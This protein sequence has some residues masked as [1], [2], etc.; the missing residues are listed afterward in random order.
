MRRALLIALVLLAAC[1]TTTTTT[2]TTPQQTTTT[3]PAATTNTSTPPPVGLQITDYAYLLRFAHETNVRPGATL[4]VL[5][6]CR[7]KPALNSGVVSFGA[8]G[9]PVASGSPTPAADGGLAFDIPL[10]GDLPPGSYVVGASCFDVSNGN[11]L[12][13]LVDQGY[14]RE[15]TVALDAPAEP[16]PVLDFVAKLSGG[17]V[18]LARAAR[19]DRLTAPVGGTISGAGQCLKHNGPIFPAYDVQIAGWK[20]A[21]F[22]GLPLITEGPVGPNGEFTFQAQLPADIPEGRYGIAVSCG[23]CAEFAGCGIGF[24]FTIGNPP[25]DTTTTTP[26]TVTTKAGLSTG[27]TG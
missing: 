9:L 3:A 23:R 4:H 18:I 13:V 27:L 17:S 24:N 26:D 19:L 16:L 10:P 20:P 12:A 11:D 21:D 7:W 2:T 1:A 25:P 8:L 5:G 15:V 14:G 22:F 6:T